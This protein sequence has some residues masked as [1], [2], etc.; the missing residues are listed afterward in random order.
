MEIRAADDAPSEPET[1]LRSIVEQLGRDG[2]GWREDGE[3]WV[4]TL[5]LRVAKP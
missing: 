3:T 2:D 5:T 1:L 4:S